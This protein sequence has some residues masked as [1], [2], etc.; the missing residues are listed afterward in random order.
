MEG[1]EGRKY[2]Q[3]CLRARSELK[4]KV[5][6]GFFSL[7]I[8]GDTAHSAVVH[9]TSYYLPCTFF[10]P[11]PVSIISSLSYRLAI[12]R[13]GIH[14]HLG[15]HASWPISLITR[16]QSIGT[17][18]RCIIQPPPLQLNQKK[19]REK[20]KKKEKSISA[21]CML[22]DRRKLIPEKYLP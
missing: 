21:S 13:R 6:Q 1:M 14:V 16:Y 10:I 22:H 17:T 2:M 15:M 11:I 20:K 8:G 3:R 7:S 19:E 9:I 18:R 4:L 5:V 12:P